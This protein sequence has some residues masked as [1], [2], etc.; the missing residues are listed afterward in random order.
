MLTLHEEQQMKLHYLQ[1]TKTQKN[2]EN[3]KKQNA[4]PLKLHDGQP[5]PPLMFFVSRIHRNFS[6]ISLLFHPYLYLGLVHTEKE[7]T[8][9]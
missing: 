2:S 4:T 6:S 3:I 7:L 5:S 1:T 8:H 9:F